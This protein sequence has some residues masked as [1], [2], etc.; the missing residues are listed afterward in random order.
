MDELFFFWDSCCICERQTKKQTAALSNTIGLDNV[1]IMGARVCVCVCV[2]GEVKKVQGWSIG[3]GG[4]HFGQQ[5]VP[6]EFDRQT[7]V[8]MVMFNCMLWGGN[9][10]KWRKMGVYV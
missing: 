10:E 4:G 2:P 8:F 1:S 3:E 5:Q 7:R 6:Q 9:G